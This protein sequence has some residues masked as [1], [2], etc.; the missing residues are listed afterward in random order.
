MWNQTKRDLRRTGVFGAGSCSCGRMCFGAAHVTD[1]TS[2]MNAARPVMRTL[3]RTLVMRTLVMRTLA[4]R[5][6]F[7][8]LRVIQCNKKKYYLIW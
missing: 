4:M 6:H 5:S 2:S 1:L 8:L 7:F 3:V